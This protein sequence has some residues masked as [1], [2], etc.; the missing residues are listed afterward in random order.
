MHQLFVSVFYWL[1]HWCL[2]DEILSIENMFA[3]L[4]SLVSSGWQLLGCGFIFRGYIW[5]VL[6]KFP[7]LGT[8]LP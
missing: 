2:F 4:S 1:Q 6:K 7:S 3:S 5:T 8:R